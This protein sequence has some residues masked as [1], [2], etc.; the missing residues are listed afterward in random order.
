MRL[1]QAVDGYIAHKRSL[2]MGFHGETVRLH[3]FIKAVGDVNISRVRPE[4]V[5]RFLD[6]TGPLSRSFGLASTTP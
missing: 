6:G 4:P 1:S 2:G 3:A 5:R